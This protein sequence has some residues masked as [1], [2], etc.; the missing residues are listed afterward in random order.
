MQGSAIKNMR[1][2]Q[3]NRGFES[4]RITRNYYSLKAEQDVLEGRHELH[5]DILLE[6]RKDEDSAAKRIQRVYRERR[7]R[8]ESMVAFNLECSAG[9]RESQSNILLHSLITGTNL[10]REF[11]RRTITGTSGGTSSP[12][13][14]ISNIDRMPSLNALQTL[15]QGR[16]QT[17]S[18]V[19]YRGMKHFKDQNKIANL[20]VTHSLKSPELNQEHIVVHTRLKESRKEQT[21]TILVGDIMVPFVKR[22]FAKHID[23]CLLSKLQYSNEKRKIVYNKESDE[24]YEDSPKSPLKQGKKADGSPTF[25]KNF[26]GSD[27]HSVILKPL[28]RAD[29]TNSTGMT[30]KCGA[31]MCTIQKYLKASQAR[32]QLKLLKLASAKSRRLLRRIY[33]KVDDVYI[34]IEHF[35]SIPT[36]CID[37]IAKHIEDHSIA[38]KCSIPLEQF[39]DEDGNLIK[40]IENAR[41][42]S[43]QTLDHWLSEPLHE[44]GLRSIY[45][46]SKQYVKI[47]FQKPEGSTK[48]THD[49]IYHFGLNMEE[50][51]EKTKQTKE[52]SQTVEAFSD[53]HKQQEL[54]QEKEEQ[55]KSKPQQKW[56]EKLNRA[57]IVV[58]KHVRKAQA[59]ELVEHLKLAIASRSHQN[60]ANK[61]LVCTLLAKKNGIDW[62][63]TVFRAESDP[64]MLYFKALEADR[65]LYQPR[66]TA[67]GLYKVET[68]RLINTNGK[69]FEKILVERMQIE[70]GRIVFDDVESSAKN[71]GI[72]TL[73]SSL[74]CLRFCILMHHLLLIIPDSSALRTC[75]SMLKS[76][77][78]YHKFTTS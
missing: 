55:V 54:Q 10:N 3:A 11:T 40:H 14:T 25:G 42:V 31:A 51:H 78:S 77:P 5:E 22:S 38:S 37:I 49:L 30:N 45:E 35:V 53:V 74:F 7:K 50:H 20:V 73:F 65:A 58:Q 32:K 59:A 41:V 15:Y 16:A 24:Y 29:T 76:S 66:M 52:Q 18:L 46:T 1:V 57:A 17:N 47:G 34:E 44:I 21:L 4:Y 67:A 70:N 19:I 64:S 13:K 60:G 23:E 48:L 43:K 9:F 6:A 72:L 62:L 8:E 39:D 36:H 26:R 56:R 28:V 63:V 27:K 69:S 33:Q 12:G 71:Y 68:Q 61:K 75:T 2:L